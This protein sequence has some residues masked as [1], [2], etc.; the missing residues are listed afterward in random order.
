M[1]RPP[2]SDTAGPVVLNL[3]QA[4]DIGGVLIK[5]SGC[6]HE[7]LAMRGRDNQRMVARG[8]NYIL[9]GHLKSSILQ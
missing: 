5:G 2:S 1:A 4:V 9:F 8:G 6:H 3:V 7:M